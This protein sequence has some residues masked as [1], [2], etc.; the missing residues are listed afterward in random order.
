VRALHARCSRKQGNTRCQAH[1]QAVG[2]SASVSVAPRARTEL[3]PRCQARA[4]RLPAP[5]ATSTYLYSYT[6]PAGSDRPTRHRSPG[7]QSIS[8]PFASTQEPARHPTSLTPDRRPAEPQPHPRH[9]VQYLH[10]FVSGQQAGEAER[11]IFPRTQV[12]VRADQA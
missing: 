1:V 9:F 6:P 3:L 5:P 7:V 12:G 4:W 10:P 8:G 11:G 2:T